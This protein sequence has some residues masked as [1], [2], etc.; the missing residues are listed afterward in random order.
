[1]TLYPIVSHCIIYGAS[2]EDRNKRLEKVLQ[3]LQENNLKSQPD[4]CEFLRKETIYL[5]HI[6]SGE[7]GISPDPSKLTAIKE[8]PTPKKVKDIQFFI[9]LAGYYRK[10]S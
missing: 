10:F 2:R 5:G 6:I 4:K 8:F 9:S 7:N 1:M 3:K